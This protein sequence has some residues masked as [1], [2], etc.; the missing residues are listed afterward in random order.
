MHACPS[1][2]GSNAF[3]CA[4]PSSLTTPLAF[5]AVQYGG[6]G[7]KQVHTTVREVTVRQLLRENMSGASEDT[8]V[9]GVELAMV[10]LENEDSRAHSGIDKCMQRGAM[11]LCA[12]AG[13]VLCTDYSGSTCCTHEHTW[14]TMLLSYPPTAPGTCLLCSSSS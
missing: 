12:C 6:G 8:R 13:Q 1:Q 11:R 4:P 5:G 2:G 10:R 7:S 3:A 9:D 14:C